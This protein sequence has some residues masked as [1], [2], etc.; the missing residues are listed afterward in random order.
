MASESTILGFLPTPDYPARTLQLQP[1]DCL[2]LY[3][4]GITEAMDEQGEMFGDDRLAAVFAQ[5]APNRSAKRIIDGV[6]QEL[7]RFRKGQVGTD[8][9]TAVVIR[10]HGPTP[11]TG[12][13]R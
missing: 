9:V 5:L 13:D 10:Y 8:D 12:V 11:G 1:G 6:M 3:T 4:D 2:L 7:D